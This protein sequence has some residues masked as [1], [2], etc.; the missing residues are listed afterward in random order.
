VSLK[1]CRTCGCEKHQDDFHFKKKKGTYESEC[2]ACAND[3]SRR[4]REANRDKI[5]EQRKQYREENK[6]DHLHKK[7]VRS[8]RSQYGITESEYLDIL[9]SQNGACA[10]C[11]TS[12]SNSTKRFA[13]DHNHDTGEVRGVL[14]SSCNLGLGNLGDSP[15]RLLSAFRYLLE[16]GHYG[17]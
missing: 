14:C 5:S 8:L 7:W 2:K 9:S 13:V 12:E 4:Y 10:I 1:Q 6:E 11:G 3:R 17:D 16:R 15:E